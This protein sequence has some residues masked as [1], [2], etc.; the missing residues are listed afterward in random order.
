MVL[1][2]SI[3]NGEGSIRINKERQETEGEGEPCLPGFKCTRRGLGARVS[4]TRSI[5]VSQFLEIRCFQSSHFATIEGE[6]NK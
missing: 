3:F 4:D 2:A 1:P 5:H 6:M